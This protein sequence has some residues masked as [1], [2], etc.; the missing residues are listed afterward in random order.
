MLIVAAIIIAGGMLGVTM[1]LARMQTATE[2]RLAELEH[3][4]TVVDVEF[5]RRE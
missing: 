1:Q 2:R 5:R 3:E 4:G